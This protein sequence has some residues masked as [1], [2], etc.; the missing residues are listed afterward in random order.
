MLGAGG[1]RPISGE[2]EERAEKKRPMVSSQSRNLPGNRWWRHSAL[3]SNHLLTVCVSATVNSL[4]VCCEHTVHPEKRRRSVSRLA[5]PP[6][7]SPSSIVSLPPPP[8]CSPDDII[9]VKY[10]ESDSP[11]SIS[12]HILTK[13]SFSIN[14]VISSSLFSPPSAWRERGRRGRRGRPRKRV[15]PREGEE[16][17]E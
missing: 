7:S 12:L 16:E 9:P 11:P 8:S 2:H 14:E 15:K 6:P 13:L 10:I 5:S 3:G 4:C 1:G 17:R